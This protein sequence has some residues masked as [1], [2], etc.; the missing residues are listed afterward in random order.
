MT[1]CRTDGAE[2]PKILEYPNLNAQLDAIIEIIRN[3]QLEDVGIFLRDNIDVKNA[4]EYF[5]RKGLNVEVKYDIKNGPSKMTLNFNT[6][7]PKITTYHSSKGLQFEAVFI[8]NCN[9]E[10]EDDRI[11]LY[12]AITRTYQSLFIMHSG[13]LSSFFDDVPTELYETSLVSKTSRRL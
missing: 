2:L 5:T 7:K 4:E 12:V 11:P 13:D 8:P 1:R 3:R 9:V 10:D 6:D